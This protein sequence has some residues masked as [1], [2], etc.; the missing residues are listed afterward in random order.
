MT[1]TSPDTA[2]LTPRARAVLDDLM[3]QGIGDEVA[4]WREN[5]IASGQAVSGADQ[6]QFATSVIHDRL[7]HIAERDISNGI[8]A[9][10]PADDAA[11]VL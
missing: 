8:G 1:M 10:S 7:R 6:R 4:A 2:T 5:A 3:A 9:L 11:V